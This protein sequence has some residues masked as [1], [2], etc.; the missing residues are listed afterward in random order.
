MEQL[1]SS[2]QTNSAEAERQIAQVTGNAERVLGQASAADASERVFIAD[3]PRSSRAHIRRAATGNAERVASARGTSL[4]TVTGN[5]ERVIGHVTGEVERS[6]TAVSTGISTV[7]KQNATDVE[8]TLLGVSAEVARSFVGKAD[9]ISAQVSARAN[10]MT[11]I[12][13]GSSST[14]LAALSNKSQEFTGEVSK[15]TDHA[16]KSI[17]AQGFT[18]TR[19]MMD[20]SEQIARLVNEASE[21][22]TSAVNLTLK[23]LQETTQRRDRAVEARPRRPAVS[24]MLETHGMLRSDTTTLFERLREANIL[25]QE[26]LSGAHE[27]MSALE[28]TLVTRVSEFVATMNEVAERSGVASNQVDQHISSFHAV[29]SKVADAISASS[30][31]IRAARPLAGRGGRPDRQEQPPHRRDPRRAPQPRSRRSSPR[32]TPAPTTSSSASSAS[33][34]CSTSR[35]TAP[36]AAPANRPHHRG[37]ER[38]K[39]LQ[40]AWSRSARPHQR[41]DARH[42]RPAQPA[43]PR[44]CSPAPRSASPNCCR[45]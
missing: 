30:P 22:A 2:I 18:F 14:L 16:V 41:D 19:T 6:L 37:I 24:E 4:A 27:N 28:N 39:A 32:S 33:P 20:N 15:A 35:S 23:N 13:D 10:E 7:L 11:R 40:R 43:K 38:A 44:R 5:A 34:A 17:E 8:R 45:A 36:P 9:E 42:L 25:L 21:T 1:A 29:T 31:A 26:V 3:A 12:L